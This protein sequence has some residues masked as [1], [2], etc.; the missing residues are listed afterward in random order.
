MQDK[1]PLRYKCVD[2][3]WHTEQPDVWQNQPG[4]NYIS[5]YVCTLMPFLIISP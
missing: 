1:T 3:P 5:F 2:S 4:E